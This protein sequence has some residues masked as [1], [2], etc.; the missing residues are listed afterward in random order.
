[1]IQVIATIT[2]RPDCQKRVVAELSKIRSTVMAEVGCH[3]YQAYIGIPSVE[4]G[5][6]AECR[7]D[8]VTVIERWESVRHLEHHLEMPHMKAYQKTV[9]PWVMSV[10]LHILQ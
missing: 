1:M 8:T 4:L 5:G 3:A 9:E 6:L 7:S 10:E 2:T